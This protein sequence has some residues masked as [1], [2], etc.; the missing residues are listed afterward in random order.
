MR[1]LRTIGKINI[2]PHSGPEDTYVQVLAGSI[3][4]VTPDSRGYALLIVRH[5]HFHQVHGELELVQITKIEN[6]YVV[7][8]RRYW[9]TLVTHLHHLVHSTLNLSLL[10]KTN[11]DIMATF[12][13]EIVPTVSKL[14]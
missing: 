1:L 3:E 10:D 14:F 12:S 2:N 9:H 13:R 6:Q 7:Q 5:S 8:P 4:Q 11:H